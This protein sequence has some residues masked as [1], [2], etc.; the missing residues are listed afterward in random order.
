M[1]NFVL[2]I[3]RILYNIYRMRHSRIP[4]NGQWAIGNGFGLGF[5]AIHTHG[6]RLSS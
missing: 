5:E 2:I 3:I 1:T 6:M 4:G